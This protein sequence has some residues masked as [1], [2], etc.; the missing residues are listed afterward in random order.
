M[1]TLSKEEYKL[2]RRKARTLEQKFCFYEEVDTNKDRTI[3]GGALEIIVMNSLTE[4][5]IAHCV[6]D[7][8]SWLKNLVDGMQVACQ[9][10]L[11]P[12]SPYNNKLIETMRLR[13]NAIIA[14][15]MEV[16]YGKQLELPF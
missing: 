12:D 1:S 8:P 2:V 5:V 14:A 7:A 13:V 15:R 16:A 9:R 10:S 4:K 6:A 3:D 11:G